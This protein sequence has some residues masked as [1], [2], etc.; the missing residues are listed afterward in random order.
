MIVYECQCCGAIFDDPD[1]K[2]D[3]ICD[4]EYPKSFSEELV[5]LCP[6]CESSDIIKKREEEE[7][8]ED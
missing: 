6:L 7:D 8:E 4:P 2:Q 3:A 5:P 1:Y